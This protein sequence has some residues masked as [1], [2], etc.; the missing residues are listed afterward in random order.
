MEWRLVQLMRRNQPSTEVQS[1]FGALESNDVECPFNYPKTL[2]WDVALQKIIYPNNPQLRHGPNLR[3][4]ATACL[5]EDLGTAPP[6][7]KYKYTV[8]TSIPPD[9]ECALWKALPG[10]LQ[11]V[12]LFR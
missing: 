8:N 9:V 10:H 2:L 4:T 12:P 6:M 5:D 7:H 11:T 3:C 1:Q